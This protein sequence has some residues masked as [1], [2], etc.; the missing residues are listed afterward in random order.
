[1]TVD[2]VQ[3][4]I[5][6]HNRHTVV[7]PEFETQ[8]A[9]WEASRIAHYSMTI[10][11]SHPPLLC[12]TAPVE[13]IGNRIVDCENDPARIE[14]WGESCD[15]HHALTINEVFDLLDAFIYDRASQASGS[16]VEVIY[17]EEYGFPAQVIITRASQVAH[18]PRYIIT[19]FKALDQE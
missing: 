3:L 4:R 9:K 11:N 13:V 16:K 10:T 19:E 18:L 12:G 1:M 8:R 14:L 15:C 6:D 7:R 2:F 5:N 17:D